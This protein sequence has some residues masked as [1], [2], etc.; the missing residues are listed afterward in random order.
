MISWRSGGGVGRGDRS[1][2]GGEY[3]GKGRVGGDQE[4]SQ[5]VEVDAA[6]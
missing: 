6:M 4:K 2:R 5:D 1:G 3:A